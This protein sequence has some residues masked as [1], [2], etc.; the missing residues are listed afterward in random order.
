M[1]VIKIIL[2]VL[3]A[4]LA[5][6]L[7]LQLI[8]AHKLHEMHKLHHRMHHKFEEWFQKQDN[9]GWASKAG[10]V[11]ERQAATEHARQMH[12]GIDMQ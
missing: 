11:Q 6:S 3:V 8:Q 10:Y 2:Y 7:I 12:T 1:Q 4:Y 5:V 9:L